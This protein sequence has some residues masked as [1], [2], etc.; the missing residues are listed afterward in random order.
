[1]KAQCD[2]DNQRLS[3]ISMSNCHL[4]IMD[5]IFTSVDINECTSSPCVHGTCSDE[6][7]EYS[8]TCDAGYKGDQCEEDINEC[9]TTPCL[10]GSCTDG[11]N[12]YT[13]TCDAGFEGQNCDQGK[14]IMNVTQGNKC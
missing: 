11:V 12:E 2:A 9:S 10:H 7:N 3:Q 6:V 8:C 1:M 5:F 13:C 4:I 14:S